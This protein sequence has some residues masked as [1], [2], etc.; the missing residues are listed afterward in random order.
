[1]YDEP[2]A[3]PAQASCTEI[4]PSSELAPADAALRDVGP[5]QHHDAGKADDEAD[6][7]AHVK[8]A[9]A[10]DERFDADHPERTRADQDGGE[11]ARQVLHAPHDAAVAEQKHEEAEH[12]ETAPR[13]ARRQRVAARGETDGENETG[14][15]VAQ[16]ALQEWRNGLERDLDG[17]VRR[18]PDEAH[19]DPGQPGAA[20]LPRRGRDRR[21]HDAGGLYSTR[22]RYRWYAVNAPSVSSSAR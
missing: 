6:P 4:T 13:G 22:S 16:A 12:G 19:R 11:S 2:I 10:R 8:R 9:A 3:Q 15:D 1:M 20:D 21:A 5:H 7:L 17:D 18:A 14:G